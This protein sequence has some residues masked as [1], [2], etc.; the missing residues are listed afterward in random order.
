MVD[1]KQLE[2]EMNQF[3]I[4]L[5]E[6]SKLGLKDFDNDGASENFIDA[7][8]DMKEN[9]QEALYAIESLTEEME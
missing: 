6:L 1:L 2:E 9:V 3:K 8:F 7:I 4:K 5:D